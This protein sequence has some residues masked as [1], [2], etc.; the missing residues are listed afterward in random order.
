MDRKEYQ[1]KWKREQRERNSPY[2]QRQREAKRSTDCKEKRKIIRNTR[3]NKEKEKLYQ[4]EY[5]SRPEVIKKTKARN[6][7]KWA[8]M[9]GRIKRPSAC[10]NCGVKDTPLKDG[11]SGLRMD[12]YLGY[13]KENWLNVKFICVQCD[14]LQL[15]KIY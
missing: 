14:G 6:R 12:H 2:A 3:G 7:A 11:R 5:R 13:E 1:N 10:E 4:K 15:R 9:Q 8:L